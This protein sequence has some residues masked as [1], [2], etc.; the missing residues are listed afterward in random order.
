MTDGRGNT[1]EMARIFPR[2]FTTIAA[3]PAKIK[4][5]AR[6]VLQIL[7]GSKLAFNTKT[8]SCTEPPQSARLYRLFYFVNL[9]KEAV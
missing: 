2:P 7:I 5:M 9:S 4:P 1:C 3:F 6:R 8:G